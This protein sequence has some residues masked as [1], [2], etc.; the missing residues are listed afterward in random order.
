MAGE[1]VRYTAG[2]TAQSYEWTVLNSRIFL[3]KRSRARIYIFPYAGHPRYRV[4]LD[5]DPVKTFRK[6]ITHPGLRIGRLQHL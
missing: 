5:N 1:P 4:K 2:G 6:T 3:S